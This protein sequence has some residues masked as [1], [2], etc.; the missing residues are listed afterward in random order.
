MDGNFKGTIFVRSIWHN[1]KKTTTM[2]TSQKIETVAIEHA[3]YLIR[4][5]GYNVWGVKKIQDMVNRIIKRHTE[6]NTKESDLDML[7]KKYNDLKS[8]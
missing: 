3:N 8:K 2:T 7:I 4:E 6:N 1:A 5:A